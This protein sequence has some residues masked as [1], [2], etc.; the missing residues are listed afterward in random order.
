[1]KRVF[2]LLF[3]TAQ[4]LVVSCTTESD[5]SSSSTTGNN[6]TEDPTSHLQATG[7]SSN[8][9]LSST[10]FNSMVVELVYVDGFEPSQSSVDNFVSFLESRTFKPNGISVEKRAITSPGNA[11]YTNAE[12]R[13]IEDINRTKF[14]TEN[15]IAVWAFFADGSSASNSGNAVVLGTAYRNTSFVIYQETIQDLSNSTFEPN[16]TVLETTVITH[17]FGHILGLT[18]LG[19]ALQSAHEDAE[20]E[21]HCNVDSC[22]MYWASETGSGL[23]NL[24]GQSQAP[25]LDAQCIADLQANGGK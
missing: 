15:E 16:R 11:P 13:S 12:I 19:A 24:V 10:T 5:N 2:F 9:L 6:N 22:L 21:K 17:E 14:N 1:M 20:H 18:N 3:I 4:I 25:Q 7:A 23:D 8:D